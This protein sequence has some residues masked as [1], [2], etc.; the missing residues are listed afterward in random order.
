MGAGRSGSTI[1]NTLLGGAENVIALGDLMQIYE[2]K[3]Q[4]KICGDGER[5]D[6]SPFWTEVVAS[7]REGLFDNAEQTARHNYALEHHS[8][9]FRTLFTVCRERAIERYL[10][11]QASL[12]SA[13]AKVSNKKVIV[14]SSK[15]PLRA[16]LLSKLDKNF[17]VNFIYNIRDARGVVFSFSKNVQTPRGNLSALA[18]YIVINFLSQITYWLLPF[19]SKC[20]VK[21]EELVSDPK[22]TFDNLSEVFNTPF[23]GV[24]DKIMKDEVFSVGPIIE[25]NRMA[26]AGRIKL[27]ED[28]QWRHELSRF[29]QLLIFLL[30][31]PIMLMNRYGP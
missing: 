28:N 22:A 20:K 12:F 3:S 25:G 23:I 26:R 29:K 21:Y 14:D 24:V 27:R 30:A 10:C 17:E 6:R 31:A 19:E 7:C 8:G 4:N 15:Y 5:F 16:Y 1:L 9:M 2:Y 18:Y 13:I 11:D